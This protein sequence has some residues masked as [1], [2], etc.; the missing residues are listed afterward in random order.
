[1]GR[2]R[3]AGRLARALKIQAAQSYR[4]IVDVGAARDV[5]DN[6]GDV[7][8]IENR[9]EPGTVRSIDRHCLGDRDGAE[10]TRI[11]DIDFTALGRFGN[12]ARKCLARRS[13]TAWISIIPHPGDPRPGGLTKSRGRKAKGNDRA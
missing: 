10:T 11:E 3:A 1:M 13:S 8:G 7:A 2:S 12:R 9:A 6:A 5:N 4:C